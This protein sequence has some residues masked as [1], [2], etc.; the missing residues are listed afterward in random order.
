M[1]NYFF[2][3]VISGIL[4]SASCKKSQ[5]IIRDNAV[6]TGAGSYPVSTNTLQDVVAI[7]NVTLGNVPLKGGYSFKTELQYFSSDPVKEINLYTTIGSGAR[8]KVFTVPYASAYSIN[9]RLDTLLVPYTV[10]TGLAAG[11]SIKLDYE[12]LN[13]NNLNLVRTATIKTQ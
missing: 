1:K 3:L 2:M 7:P 12:I 8:S 9:K 4:I 10:P 11:T 6:P 13:Q 5:D